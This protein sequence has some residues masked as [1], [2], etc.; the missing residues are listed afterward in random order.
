M[1]PIGVVHRIQGVHPGEI[2]WRIATWRRRQD[3]IVSIIVET[4]GVRTGVVT[5]PRTDMDDH[6]RL[7]AITVPAEAKR[8]EV[9][10]SGEAVKLVAEFIIR[11]H[12]IDPGWIRA[13]GWDAQGDSLDSTGA[14][15]HVLL[16]VVV[17]IIW[18]QIDIDVASVRIITYVL[19]IV[20]HC[21]R[22]GIVGQHGL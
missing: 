14:N 2:A 10:E 1:I 19:H 16:G 8:L 4:I 17:M 7:V 21:H 12:R 6:P 11:H 20:V 18:I 3:G 15:S 5:D 9:F 13:I 22:I